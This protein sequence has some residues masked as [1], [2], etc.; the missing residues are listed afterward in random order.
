MLER[1]DEMLRNKTIPF[2]KVLWKHHRSTDAT[3][4]PE[5]VMHEKY[6]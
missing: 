4:E 6:P 5:H 2:V 1:M 3:W